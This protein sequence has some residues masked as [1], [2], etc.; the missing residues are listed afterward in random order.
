MIAL[1]TGV[2]TPSPLLPYSYH[3]RIAG[4][5]ISVSLPDDDVRRLDDYVESA[6]L[7]SRSAGLREAI[8]LLGA[9]HLAAEYAEAFEEWESSSDSADWDPTVADGI[10]HEAW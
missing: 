2:A 8:K 9:S 6:G 7:P 1:T 5:K 4:M 3:G 10:D